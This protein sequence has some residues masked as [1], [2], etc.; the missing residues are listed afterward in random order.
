MPS[1]R[2]QCLQRLGCRRRGQRSA[3]RARASLPSVTRPERVWP[4]KLNR[5]SWSAPG[6]AKAWAAACQGP[7]LRAEGREELA[8]F[9]VAVD[10]DLGDRGAGQDVVELVDQHQ[11]PELGQRLGRD[12]RRRSGSAPWRRGIRAR[13]ACARR[14]GCWPC[15]WPPRSACRG[16]IAG[17]AR[18]SRSGSVLPGASILAPRRSRN[19]TMP[20]SLT[21]GRA[22]NA[23]L[24]ADAALDHGAGRAAAAIAIAIGHDAL[25][26]ARPWAR[27]A[28]RR[29]WSRE[30]E[31]SPL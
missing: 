11:F 16:D 19:G 8:V 31:R 24:E 6:L 10:I 12:R 9:V 23:A 21:C 26:R 13:A 28:S 18:R 25:R 3:A 14:C 4:V 30:T 15:S 5:R 1:A 17:R 7:L 20:S 22:G 29:P 27:S 2:D